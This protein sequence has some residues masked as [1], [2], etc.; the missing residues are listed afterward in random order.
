[1]RSTNSADGSH[2]STLIA[3]ETYT[4]PKGVRPL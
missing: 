2:S 3:C 1:V 4:F